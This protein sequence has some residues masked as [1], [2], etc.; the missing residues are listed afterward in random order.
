[1]STVN[2]R[3][4]N[5]VSNTLDSPAPMASAPPTSTR[6]GDLPASDVRMCAID[7]PSCEACQ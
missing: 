6:D 1:M 3:Q 2:Q 5:A 7:D 4:L